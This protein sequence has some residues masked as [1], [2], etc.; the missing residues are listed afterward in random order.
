MLMYLI[1]S[2]VPET[3]ETRFYGKDNAFIDAGQ[4][5]R[6]VSQFALYYGFP[7]HYMANIMKEKTPG[8]NKIVIR[9]N[10]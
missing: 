5:H 7:S 9:A 3:G 6:F 1:E 10:I 4:P 2:T 8:D